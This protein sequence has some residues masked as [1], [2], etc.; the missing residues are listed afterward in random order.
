MHLDTYDD[1]QK[2]LDAQLKKVKRRGFGPFFCQETIDSICDWMN[3]RGLSPKAGLCHGARC[4]RECDAFLKHFPAATVIGTDIKPKSG[5]TA[6]VKTISQVVHHDFMQINADWVH[7]HDFVYTNSFDHVYDPVA[8]LNVWLDQLTD[9]GHLFVQWQMGDVKGDGFGAHLD[10]YMAL[11]HQ[12]G[13]LIDLIYSYAT[14]GHRG[15]GINVILVTKRK[16]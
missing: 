9:D 1:Y 2:Y 10:E 16:Q 4:G 14:R 8:A 11:F 13:E 5:R 6:N 12:T 7:R 15:K 3:A